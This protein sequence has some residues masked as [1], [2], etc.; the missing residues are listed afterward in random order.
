M[1]DHDLRDLLREQVADLTT[2]PDLSAGAWR[3]ARGVRRRRVLA[4][5]GG[6]AAATVLAVAGIAVLGDQSSETPDP[7]PAPTGPPEPTGPAS[8]PDGHFRGAPVYWSPT[9][10]EEA[11]L[12]PMTEGRPPL[13]EEIDLSAAAVPVEADPIDGAAAAFGIS[14]DAGVERLLLLTFDRGYRTLDLSRVGPDPSISCCQRTPVYDWM[15]SPSGEYVAFPQVDGFLVYDLAEGEWRTVATS[16]DVITT[17]ASWV[18]ERELF[19]PLSSSPRSGPVYDVVTGERA[20][21]SEPVDTGA[22]ELDLERDLSYQFGQAR[23]GPAGVLQ[24]WGSGARLPVPD[25]RAQPE[26]LVAKGSRTTIL[27]FTGSPGGDGRWLQCCPVVGWASAEV[28]MYESRSATP[29]IIAWSVGSHRF[30]TVSTITG[31]TPGEQSYVG[32]YADFSE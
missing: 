17:D 5:A 29:R 12:P 21:E 30:E 14:S 22:N 7:G 8:T 2:T 13:P 23:T 1:T 32:S 11:D 6:A 4:A 31:F 3:A 24:S 15:L 10:S 27:S 25:G 20:S 18:G 28:A 19:A 9:V 16:G 26:F